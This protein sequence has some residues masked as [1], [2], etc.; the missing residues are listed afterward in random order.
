MSNKEFVTAID[1]PQP[2]DEYAVELCRSA[3]RY[4]CIMSPDLDHAAF[5]NSDL[6]DALSALARG[7]SQTQVRILVSNA[8]QIVTRGHRLLQLARRLP[9]T[10]HIQELAEHP[11]WNSETVIIRDRDGVL[12]K[13]GGS[14]HNAFYEPDSRASTTRHLELFEELWR[15]SS[16]G[17][18]L[19]SLNL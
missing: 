6:V 11:D 14:D 4:I 5:D 8:R 12:Y 13:P 9:S 1:Y 10:V 15:H 7:S 2:F 16:Q 3:S 19:R 17:V 18:E